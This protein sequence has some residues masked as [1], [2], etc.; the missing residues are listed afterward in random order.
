MHRPYE[1]PQEGT[2]EFQRPKKKKRPSKRKASP[3]APAAGPPASLV[4][5]ERG[6]GGPGAGPMDTDVFT[7]D[8]ARRFCGDLLFAAAD[9]STYEK[10][11]RAARTRFFFAHLECN[12]RWS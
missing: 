1:N 4:P 7:A 9:D 10:K 2:L 6:G 3:E 12:R 5:Q 8:E 11:R